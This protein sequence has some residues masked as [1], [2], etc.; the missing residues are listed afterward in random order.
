MPTQLG[1]NHDLGESFPKLRKRRSPYG[2]FTDPPPFDAGRGHTLPL[3]PTAPVALFRVLEEKDE[4]LVC[5]GYDPFEG[6]FWKEVAVAKPYLLQETPFD[7]QTVDDV[8]Y[9]YQSKSVRKAVHADWT[10]IQRVTPSYY[11]DTT[12]EDIIACARSFIVVADHTG[13]FDDDGKPV[14]WIDLN[15]SG[16][17]WVDDSRYQF[18]LTG[19]FSSGTATA[20]LFEMDGASLASGVTINLPSLWADSV[21]DDMQSG[22]DGTCHFQEEKYWFDVSPCGSA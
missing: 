8:T 5:E 1:G 17:R 14:E 4:Y 10:S 21:V 15:F 7:G 16:R 12:T 9:T 11:V 2:G 3:R 22:D 18:T 13:L 20:D 6:Y 19:A